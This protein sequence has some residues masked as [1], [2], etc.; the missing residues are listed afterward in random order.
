[1][2]LED[3]T[4]KR[5]LLSWVMILGLSWVPVRGEIPVAE[6]NGDVPN[7]VAKPVLLA[8]SH[9]DIFGRP[10][11]EGTMFNP[12]GIV[13]YWIEV[14]PDL[15]PTQE[16]NPIL[17]QRLQQPSLSPSGRLWMDEENLM[18]VYSDGSVRME[19][20]LE[21][22]RDSIPYIRNEKYTSWSATVGSPVAT[23]LL[24][25]LAEFPGDG[26]R[27]LIF[28]AQRENPSRWLVSVAPFT[29][30]PMKLNRLRTEG[31]FGLYQ[32]GDQ[33]VLLL[34]SGDG[35]LAWEIH[36]P[37]TFEEPLRFNLFPIPTLP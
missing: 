2:V 20:P 21:Q 25:A 4:L 14:E 37:A 23:D 36:L 28:A 1:M 6:P 32:E 22:T 19:L 24:I 12:G 15:E 13:G 26:G 29:R 3:K 27:L 31:G 18:V 17:Q 8:S 34:P 10:E 16:L 11:F 5:N 9:G 7:F 33:F 30:A 35:D